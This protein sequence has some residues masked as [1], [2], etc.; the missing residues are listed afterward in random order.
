MLPFTA[1]QFFALFESYNLAIWPAQLVAYALA[2]FLIWSIA[3]RR[4]WSW[5]LAAFI[6]GAFWLWNGLVYHLAFFTSINPAAYGFAALFIVQGVAFIA[7]GLRANSARLVVERNACTAIA[8]GLI[9]YAMVVYSIIG[10]LL[11][12]DWPRAPM[13]GVAPCPTMIFTL[14]VL[15]LARQSASMWLAAIPIAWALIGSTAAALLGVWED[16]GLLV[17]VVALMACRRA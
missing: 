4:M 8:V 6:L 9:L 2:G 15:M 5:R 1:E 13:F 10:N 14:G 17:A 16:L 12:H 11:G 3:S 7:S